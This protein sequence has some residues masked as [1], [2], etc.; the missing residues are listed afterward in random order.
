L[1]TTV[2]RTL[3]QPIDLVS[4]PLVLLVLV[5]IGGL[6]Y[7]RDARLHGRKFVQLFWWALAVRLVASLTR[8]II[9][10]YI[11]PSWGIDT[12]QYF[13]LSGVIADLFFEDPSLAF[14]LVFSSYEDY[15]L[16]AQRISTHY[17]W[18]KLRTSS[19]FRFG[20][21]LH[22]ITGGSY[23][24]ISWICTFLAFVGS[25]LIYKT[26]HRIYPQYSLLI[27]LAVLFLPTV[28]F[29]STN[30]FKDP[31]CILGLGLLCE[32]A[33]YMKE[34]GISFVPALSVGVGALILGVVKAYILLAF[35]VA[36]AVFY[37][38]ALELPVQ[39]G[40]PRKVAK[41]ILVLLGIGLIVGAGVTFI[42]FTSGRYNLGYLT[43]R[44]QYLLAGDRGAST[45]SGYALPLISLSP[46]GLTYFIWSAFNVSLFRWRVFLH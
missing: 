34:K 28:A 23:L 13:K 33:F 10:E 1:K 21:F 6:I 38:A 37:F 42:A 26:F 30:L 32:G 14:E 40:V 39:K 4:G 20:S 7:N 22:L 36:F 17:F 3:L 9:T 46:I 8:I 25:W 15:G 41:A 45:G 35:I 43:L 16:E 31:F 18:E 24:A 27:G 29:Y 2:D 11:V 19:I 44:L 12:I 5:L